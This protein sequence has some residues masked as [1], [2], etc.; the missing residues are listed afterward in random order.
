MRAEHWTTGP[1]AD[2]PG[3]VAALILATLA[4]IAAGVPLG[5][6]AYRPRR[7]RHQENRR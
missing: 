5:A 1:V 7:R 6:I 4:V 3:P 2:V